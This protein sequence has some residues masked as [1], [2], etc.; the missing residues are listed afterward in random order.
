M[1]GRLDTDHQVIIKD[2]ASQL[3]EVIITKS[4]GLLNDL[5]QRRVITAD[6]K[7]D[8]MVSLLIHILKHVSFDLVCII[9]LIHLSILYLTVIFR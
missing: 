5:V 7:D 8:I 1:Y 9:Y 4:G 6:H 2:H 3:H